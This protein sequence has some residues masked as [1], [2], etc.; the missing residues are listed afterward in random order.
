MRETAIETPRVL[1]PRVFL[2]ATRISADASIRS[3]AG[4]EHHRATKPP[5]LRRQVFRESI[6]QTARNDLVIKAQ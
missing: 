2:Y 3:G 5:R 1:T 4:P 6:A